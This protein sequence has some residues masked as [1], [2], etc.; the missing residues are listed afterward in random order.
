M[1]V[2]ALSWAANN[3][4]TKTRSASYYTDKSER[5]LLIHPEQ[6]GINLPIE[7][8]S[9]DSYSIGMWFKVT[10]VMTSDTKAGTIFHFGTYKQCGLWGA[11]WVAYHSSDQKLRL[12]I[13]ADNADKSVTGNEAAFTTESL[14]RTAAKGDLGTCTLNA[15][16]YMLISADNVNKNFKIYVDGTE[17]YSVS[18]Q[19][20]GYCFPDGAFGFM[21][22][23]VS[24]AIDEIQL[25][26]KAVSADEAA[27]AY[28]SKVKAINGLTAL[29]T[30]D[31]TSVTNSWH[32]EAPA[33]NPDDIAVMNNST[34]QKNFAYCLCY[35]ANEERIGDATGYVA[36]FTEGREMPAEEINVLIS[37][38]ENGGTLTLTNGANVFAISAEAQK[39]MSH[40]D[41][42]VV[43]TPAEGYSLVKIVVK[44]GDITNEIANNSV[45]NFGGDA[46]ITATFTSS[47]AALTVVD[48]GGITFNLF[49]G[50]ENITGQK[51]SLIPGVTYMLVPSLDHANAIHKKV[52]G[53]TLNGVEL[54]ADAQG[55]YSF[56]MPEGGA[57]FAILSRDLAAYTLT[58]EEPEGGTV[59]V[60]EGTATEL[61][62]G[63]TVYE[64]T[65][66][67]LA[68]EAMPG[69][70]FRYYTVD[71]VRYDGT[72]Y[73]PTADC[74]I[75]AYFEEGIDY[76]V[77]EPVAGRLVA[78]G[79]TSHN[80]RYISN[81]VVS[82]GTSSMTIAGNG[83]AST[84]NRPVYKDATSNVLTV[85][86]GDN[87]T[88]TITGAGTWCHVLVYADF[89]RNGFD[90]TPAGPSNPD[91]V[92]Y[93]GDWVAST[94][95]FAASYA[96]AGTH[97][98]TIPQ[99][100][101]AG[102]YRVRVMQDWDGN[103]P[104]VYG[105]SGKDNGEIIIDFLFKI[106]P[107]LLA[108]ERTVS[109]KASDD[110]MGT[111]KITSPRTSESS[112][113]TNEQTVTVK[114]TPAEGYGF[115]NWT[116][117]AGEVVS[118]DAT[119][120]Y[121]GEDD[122]EL[123]ANFGYFVNIATAVGGYVTV[124]SNGTT[125]ANGSVVAPG[126]VIKV[127][128]TPNN[129]WRL[130]SVNVNDAT[131][132]N[133]A[134]IE[135]NETINITATFTDAL[136]SLVINKQGEGVVEVIPGGY[137]NE[138]DYADVTILQ[139]GAPISNGDMIT[140]YFKP[141]EGYILSSATVSGDTLEGTGVDI[142]MED[143]A[144]DFMTADD[145]GMEMECPENWVIFDGGGADGTTD[146]VVTAVFQLS[147][148]AI[149]GVEIDGENGP[150]E[151]FNLQGVRVAGNL[152]PG[153]YV[154]RQG[155]KTVKVL[156]K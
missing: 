142:T 24:G 64:G 31:D 10:D 56:E 153:I 144:D 94:N 20:F 136:G 118:T 16:H 143:Y 3:A 51:D 114:A 36:T 91:L 148:T 130:V 120:T 133:E 86:P 82:N 99:G 21:G 7:S 11:Y 89:N 45:I 98:F 146:Y 101:G 135:V 18:G 116:N 154:R 96:M 29:Y 50:T 54:T 147:S 27:L 102:E 2:P 1:L 127:T 112:V 48:E 66:L 150:V 5:E 105:Q 37:G 67:T 111:V 84:S 106:E 107:Q 69:Y 119:Y 145:F 72:T 90:R 47:V 53:A 4:V 22:H 109:V 152:T 117:A 155:G 113:T 85:E 59:K 65:I 55:R 33:G 19:V 79:N 15:W 83:S 35:P 39:L 57:T 44:E 28:A 124:S 46:E 43:A 97:N 132:E 77:P 12:H 25:F 126:S 88:L 138:D 95:S 131:I 23:G 134:E 9:T 62:D 76:C 125:V 92:S 73:V 58:I 140:V 78:N 34:F 42:E 38:T 13:G 75:S 52:T 93:K 14:Y 60:I 151:Y 123:T 81:I 26:N 17:V 156:V 63:T 32:N 137:F 103:D 40:T 74:T 122:I 80:E 87:I 100:L 139:P 41:Y 49:K 70:Q 30:F 128:A 68:N 6:A 108:Q 121:S 104:C 129:G 110:S 141:A 71:G 8:T 149:D 61:A 115:I